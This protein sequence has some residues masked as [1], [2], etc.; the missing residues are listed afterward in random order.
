MNLSIHSVGLCCSFGTVK[1]LPHRYEL[2]TKSQVQ[3][4]V[5]VIQ[6][7]SQVHVHS[8]KSR[9]YNLFQLKGTIYRHKLL[10]VY[11]YL[12]LYFARNCSKFIDVRNQN[13]F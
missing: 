5:L 13:V 6:E 3:G 7:P 1:Y 10:T 8:Q 9:T 2:N 11:L 4:S 12:F